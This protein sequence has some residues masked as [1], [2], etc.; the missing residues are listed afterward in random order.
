MYSYDWR[1]EDLGAIKFL[2]CIALTADALYK[3]DKTMMLVYMAISGDDIGAMPKYT[4]TARKTAMWRNVHDLFMRSRI[5][6]YTC[7]SL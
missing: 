3:I 4:K 1:I 6:G 5:I 7:W 2:I